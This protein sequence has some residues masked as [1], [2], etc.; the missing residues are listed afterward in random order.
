LRAQM[1]MESLADKVGTTKGSVSQWEAGLSSGCRIDVL[2]AIADT[3]LVDPRW[4]ATGHG[5]PATTSELP[6]HIHLASQIDLIPKAAREPLIDLINSLAK[7][8]ES[9][10]WEW[11][12]EVG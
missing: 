5:E 12:K 8:S 6:T 7:A 4:L 10:F 3:L 11:A 1:S 9:R 2:F